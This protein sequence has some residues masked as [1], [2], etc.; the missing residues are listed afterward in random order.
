MIARPKHKVSVP[1]SIKHS[2]HDLLPVVRKLFRALRHVHRHVRVSFLHRN[3][4]R[5]IVREQRKLK[6]P[7]VVKLHV[8]VLFDLVPTAPAVRH[9]VAG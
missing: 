4:I 7:V 1:V 5:W 6:R 9:R 3:F 8:F 2:L